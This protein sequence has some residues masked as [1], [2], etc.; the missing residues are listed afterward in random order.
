MF[1]KLISTILAQVGATLGLT[2][3][4]GVH[5]GVM[6]AHLGVMGAHL[7]VMTAHLTTIILHLATIVGN[8]MIANTVVMTVQ[9]IASFF[10]DGGDPPVGVPSIVGERGPELFIPKQAGTI[11]PNHQLRN[12]GGAG[13]SIS[14]V[15]SVFKP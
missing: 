4:T 5:T 8:T 9:T 15:A 2:T 11:I 14:S 10:A 6:T 3:V 7:G 12:F 13:L 1:T